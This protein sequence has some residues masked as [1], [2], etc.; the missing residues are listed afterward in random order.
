[1]PALDLLTYAVPEGM[2]VPVAGARVV[3]PLGRRT[4]TGVVVGE[5]GPPD[6]AFELREVAAVLDTERFLPADVLELTNWVADY[7]LA[8]PGAALSVAMPPHA[9]DQR[10][11]AFRTVRVIRLTA[12]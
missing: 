1:V 5:A 11:E 8:G 4:L 12:E 10:V 6:A 9:L 2:P 3:V 7:Y